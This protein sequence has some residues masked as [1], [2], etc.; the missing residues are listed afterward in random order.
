MTESLEQR[1]LRLAYVEWWTPAEAAFMLGVAKSS[2]IRW[3]AAG[4]EHESG[5]D[6]RG[7]KRIRIRRQDVHNWISDET[8]RTRL[9][10]RNET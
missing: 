8:R 10:P 5:V 6:H 9:R 1:K 4:L 3:V 2:V 7:R